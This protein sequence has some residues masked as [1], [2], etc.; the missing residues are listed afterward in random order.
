MN[1]L[2]VFPQC[3]APEVDS[4]A[5]PA[6]QR[7]FPPTGRRA[8]FLQ[9]TSQTRDWAF[10]LFLVYREEVGI[11]MYISPLTVFGCSPSTCLVPQ[12]SL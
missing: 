10:L 2:G 11:N 4:I 12:W 3:A 5:G 8:S 1:Y 9:F 6:S 7:P